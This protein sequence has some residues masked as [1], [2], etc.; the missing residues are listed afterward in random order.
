[1]FKSLL[2]AKKLIVSSTKIAGQLRFQCDITTSAVSRESPIDSL[3]QPPRH[4]ATWPA[5]NDNRRLPAA[6][7]LPPAACR[8]LAN[9]PSGNPPVVRHQR[10][11]LGRPQLGN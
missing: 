11:R 6:S 8:Q 9:G 1:M 3:S 5:G 10:L 2:G 7:S 4:D